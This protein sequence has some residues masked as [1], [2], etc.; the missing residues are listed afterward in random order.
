MEKTKNKQNP[1][2]LRR[3]VAPRI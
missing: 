2:L 3:Y 1:I